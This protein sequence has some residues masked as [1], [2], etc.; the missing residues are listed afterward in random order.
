MLYAEIS[1]ACLRVFE[2]DSR[3]VRSNTEARLAILNMI[4][5]ISRREQYIEKEGRILIREERSKTYS[6][7]ESH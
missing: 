1:M 7:S 5:T 2:H 4:I 3:C 6:Y